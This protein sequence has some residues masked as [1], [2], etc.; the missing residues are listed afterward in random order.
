MPHSKNK[1]THNFKGITMKF[2]SLTD[3]SDVNVCA[4]VSKR[5]WPGWGRDV[6]QIW[7]PCGSVISGRR[8][9]SLP[10][11]PMSSAARAG[12]AMEATFIPPS[13]RPVC[14][15]RG[16]V[17]PNQA[18]TSPP[19]PQRLGLPLAPPVLTPMCMG[20]PRFCVRYIKHK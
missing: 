15:T 7:C 16:E 18:H 14:C 9:H 20:V 17:S 12:V 4:L 13:T 11:G 5:P 1:S 3:S 19:E 8:S 2:C 6:V 10:A